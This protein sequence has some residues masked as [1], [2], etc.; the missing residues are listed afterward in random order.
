[1]WT[2]GEVQGSLQRLIGNI[3]TAGAALAAPPGLVGLVGAFLTWEPQP[4]STPAQLA[5]TAARLCHLLR[6][7]VTEQVSVANQT[8]AGLAS[9]WRYLLF[10]DASD[11]EFADSYAQAVTFGLL[12]AR[13][14]NIDL[15]QGV[16]SAAAKLATQQ[17]SIVGAA[18]RIL[19]DGQ[20]AES[21]LQT[22]V[23]DRRN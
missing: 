11:D 15:S 9:D 21:A 1:L 6:D 14:R 2:D 3:E 8:L 13:V 5:L 19:T 22:F 4:P 12:T 16:S 23:G 10:P 7:E 20:L 17:H 18:L